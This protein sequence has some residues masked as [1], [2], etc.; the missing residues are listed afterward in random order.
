M[1]TTILVTQLKHL[2]ERWHSHNHIPSTINH[3]DLTNFLLTDKQVYQSK[4]KAIGFRFERLRAKH[5]LK[6]QS[7]RYRSQE[8]NRRQDL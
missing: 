4:G 3:S 5:R 2:K 7:K 1:L 8:A 6:D